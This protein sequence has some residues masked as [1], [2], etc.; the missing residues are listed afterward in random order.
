MLT[1]DIPIKDPRKPPVLK[2]P[3]RCVNCGKPKETSMSLRLNMGAQ[4]RG[5]MVTLDLSVPLC[6]VCEKKEQKIGNVTWIPF[7]VSGILICVIVFIPTWLLT[8]Q[9][10]TLQTLNFDLV[11]GSFAGL[12]AGLIGGTLVEFGLKFAFASIYGR[13]LWSRPLTVVSVFT[14]AENLI[15]FSTKFT[16]GRKSILFMF[17]NDEIARE[18]TALNLQEKS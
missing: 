10:P 17:E 3:E 7:F 14:D 11:V 16:E 1:V 13:L 12:V 15:G 4:K 2:F 6:G 8:P 18:F 9:G 5:Q